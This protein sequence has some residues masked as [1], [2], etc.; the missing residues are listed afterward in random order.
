MPS[1][2]SFCQSI[3]SLNTP[4]YIYIYISGLVRPQGRPKKKKNLSKIHLKASKDRYGRQDTYISKCNFFHMLE[5]RGSGGPMV[6]RFCQPLV[7]TASQLCQSLKIFGPIEPEIW[8]F[9]YL[10]WLSLPWWW[11][12]WWPWYTTF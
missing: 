4:R 8:G 1:T 10:P 11:W 5:I 7:L 9:E 3:I 6:T 2:L 12:P